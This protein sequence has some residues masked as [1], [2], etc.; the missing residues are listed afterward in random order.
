MPDMSSFVN[1]LIAGAGAVLALM[2]VAYLRI[3]TPLEGVMGVSSTD[4]R[5]AIFLGGIVCAVAVAYEYYGKKQT[6]EQQEKKPMLSFVDVN[7][8][9]RHYIRRYLTEL[10]Y[11]KWFDRNHPDYKIYE[12]VGLSKSEYQNIT[13]ELELKPD[14]KDVM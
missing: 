9:P 5:V 8:D 14:P 13:K 12:A 11:R 3:V 4:I 2:S 10:K 1:G 7:K 6:K